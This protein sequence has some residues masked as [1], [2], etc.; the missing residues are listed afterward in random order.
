MHK[1]I[2]EENKSAKQFSHDVPKG[3][4][5]TIKETAV[6]TCAVIHVFPSLG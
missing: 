2:N 3:T 6:A 4:F 5:I 1:A